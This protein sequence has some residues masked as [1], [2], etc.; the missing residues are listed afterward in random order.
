MEPGRQIEA[1][2]FS[3]ETIFKELESERFIE[4]TYIRDISNSFI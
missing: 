2:L 4:Y 1:R 3:L